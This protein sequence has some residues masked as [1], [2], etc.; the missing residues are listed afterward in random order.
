M[1]IGRDNIE[2]DDEPPARTGGDG[3]TDIEIVL[4][5]LVFRAGETINGHLILTPH[6]DMSDCELSI[7]WGQRR[8]SHPLV[9]TPAVGGGG[10]R[11]DTIKLGKGIPL[12]NGTRGDGAVRRAAAGGCAADRHSGALNTGV[13]S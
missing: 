13:V 2:F 4:P 11:G 1:V 7:H 12:R 6:E 3:R 10:R 9:R 8:I 5:S